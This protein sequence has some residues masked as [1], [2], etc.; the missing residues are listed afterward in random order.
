MA[1]DDAKR[2]WTWLAEQERSR[3]VAVELRARF[4]ADLGGRTPVTLGVRGGEPVARLDPATRGAVGGI[5]V[6][7]IVAQHE[8][9]VQGQRWRE[10][11]VEARGRQELSP[12]AVCRLVLGPLHCPARRVFSFNANLELLVDPA[13]AARW[14]DEVDAAD[15]SWPSL[16]RCSRAI[17]TS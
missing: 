12:N 5:D 6:E 9:P 8:D 14:L 17:G 4:R 1:S 7:R 10:A 16:G 15:P 3:G 13:D 2:F 11:F